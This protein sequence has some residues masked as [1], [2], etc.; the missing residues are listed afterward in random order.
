MFDGKTISIRD[1]WHGKP[2]YGKSYIDGA[3]TIII[4]GKEV[5]PIDVKDWQLYNAVM[6]H[7]DS[8]NLRRMHL[9]K[10]F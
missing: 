8:Q 9:N 3:D 6:K 5:N 10:S 1:R 7:F 4:D 2:S